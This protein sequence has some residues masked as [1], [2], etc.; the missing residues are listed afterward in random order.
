MHCVL[1]ELQLGVRPTAERRHALRAGSGSTLTREVN[2]QRSPERL[3]PS[4]ESD[5]LS[6]MIA[7]IQ[8][9][10][11]M[12]YSLSLSDIKFPNRTACSIPDS[13]QI[14][15]FLP[16]SP[17]QNGRSLTT[18]LRGSKPAGPG[19]FRVLDSVD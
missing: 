2:V 7:A 11:D 17:V 3:S 18:I 14:R 8:V 5:L 12:W 16:P 6:L 9:P 19:V 4:P 1:A 15:L 10:L 13:A